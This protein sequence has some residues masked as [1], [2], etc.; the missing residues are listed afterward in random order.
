LEAAA[1]ADTASVLEAAAAAAEAAAEKAA[2]AA[3]L[4]LQVTN[5]LCP[6]AFI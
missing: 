3:E 5:G 4:K 6:L 2:A 1:K